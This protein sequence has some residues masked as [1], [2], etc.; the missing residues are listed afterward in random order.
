MKLAQL[1][2]DEDHDRLLREREKVNNFFCRLNVGGWQSKQNKGSHTIKCLGLE[3]LEIMKGI[4][5][6]GSLSVWFWRFKFG[7]LEPKFLVC[8]FWMLKGVK[9]MK[10]GTP[11][12]D[13][14]L[15]IC[16]CIH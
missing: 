3:A 2:H 5:G 7:I 12:K 11:T 15:K 1:K 16:I 14:F 10:M 6:F 8:E 9:P 4:R 13:G